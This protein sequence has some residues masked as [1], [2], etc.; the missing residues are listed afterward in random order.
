MN[1]YINRI[2]KYWKQY[3]SITNGCGKDPGLYVIFNKKTL[4]S[5]I[6]ESYSIENRFISHKLSLISNNHFN[7]GL[8]KSVQEH[9]MDSLIFFVIDYGN[10]YQN[11]ESRRLAE[12]EVINSW[13]GQIYN[14]KDVDKKKRK[15]SL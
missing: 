11:V 8:Q 13:P 2:Y 4:V 1:I 7:R 3:K 10:N 5:Y 6:G 12:I 14:I 15:N 9:G